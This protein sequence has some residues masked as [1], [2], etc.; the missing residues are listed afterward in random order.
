MT[1]PDTSS[2]RRPLAGGQAFVLPVRRD[3]AS[4]KVAMFLILFGFFFAG[5]P[6]FAVS[7]FFAA[8][9]GP[10]GLFAEL[11]A[12]PFFRIGPRGTPTLNDAKQALAIRAAWGFVRGLG[13]SPS[14]TTTSPSTTAPCGA[15]S[16]CTSVTND[17]RLGRAAHGDFPIAL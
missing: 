9:V 8:A 2:Q 4:A 16:A 7:G 1:D 14:V 15:A 10:F 5:V 3:P 17:G 13:C 11:F 6:A 12:L